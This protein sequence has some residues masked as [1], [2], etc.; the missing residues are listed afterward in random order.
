M[1]RRLTTS[2]PA[3][4]NPVFISVSPSSSSSFGVLVPFLNLRTFL[5]SM[6][7]INSQVSTFPNS[8]SDCTTRTIF[9]ERTSNRKYTHSSLEKYP[10]PFPSTLLSPGPCRPSRSSAAMSSF[11][12]RA[13]V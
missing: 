4:W 13:T 3:G 1:N 2:M 11:T 6:L 5:G 8:F 9:E 10:L 12:H 7:A